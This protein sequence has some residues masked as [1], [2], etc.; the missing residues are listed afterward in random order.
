MFWLLVKHWTLKSWVWLKTYWCAGVWLMTSYFLYKFFLYK[1]EEETFAQTVEKKLKVG[2]EELKVLEQRHRQE[3]QNLCPVHKKAE[4]T[5][6]LIN[7]GKQAP[8][9]KE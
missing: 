1:K 6:W 2:N 5:H 3:L 7:Q 8:E 9:L 4:A